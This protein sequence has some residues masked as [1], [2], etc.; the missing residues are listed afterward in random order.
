V[1]PSVFRVG[2]AHRTVAAPVVVPPD[3]DTAIEN[4]DRPVLVFPSLTRIW[5]LLAVP[6]VEGVPERR[7]V[8][9]L[10]VAH[11]GLLV[12]LKVSGSP[13]ASFAVGW[14]L[15]AVLTR[16]VV[17][18]VP[19]IVG[20]EFPV[21]PP[22][23]D[24]AMLNDG[25]EADVTPSVTTIRIDENVPV[26]DGVPDRRPVDVLNVAQDGLLRTEKVSVRP[27]GS[28]AVGVKVYA[29]PTRAV[30]GGVPVMVGDWFEFGLTV[31][32][33][34]GSE[35]LVLPSVTEMTMLLQIFACSAYGTPESWPVLVENDAKAGLLTIENVSRLPSESLAVGLK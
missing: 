31:S 26:D 25:S 3:V 34:E 15:Y 6:V 20:A 24:T 33:K 2:G 7:P 10:N 17:A 18:G 27:S 12:M 35:T 11:E 23:L 32:E 14:K 9:V 21:L 19:L 1:L 28:L 5:M 16:A 30:V 22:E 4:A 13:F 29:V 8:D